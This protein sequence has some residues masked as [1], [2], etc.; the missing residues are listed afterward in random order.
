MLD[1]GQIEAAISLNDFTME[2]RRPGSRVSK[3][4]DKRPT[5][6]GAPPIQLVSMKYTQDSEQNKNSSFF[7]YYC[8]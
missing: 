1:D 2:D 7:L 8:Y 4:M 5:L 3:L 6:S